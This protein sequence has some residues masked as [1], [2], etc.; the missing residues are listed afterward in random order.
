MSEFGLARGLG[1]GVRA[2][3]VLQAGG[4][5]ARFLT[6]WFGGVSGGVEVGWDGG[7]L[8]RC[9]RSLPLLLALPTNFNRWAQ[10][11]HTIWVGAIGFEQV[12]T[13]DGAEGE[14]WS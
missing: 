8:G 6:L 13:A 4:G 12:N 7:F 14:Y 11:V 1:R 3:L 10:R 9:G 2:L 5:G